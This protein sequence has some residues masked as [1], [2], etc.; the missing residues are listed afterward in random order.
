[1]M[2]T[3]EVMKNLCGKEVKAVKTALVEMGFNFTEELETEDFCGYITVE[4]HDNDLGSGFYFTYENGITDGWDW[5][6]W[7]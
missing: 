3:K 1:M 4:G 2:M 7:D 5:L 6:G